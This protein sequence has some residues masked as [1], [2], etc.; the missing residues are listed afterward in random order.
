MRFLWTSAGCYDQIPMNT[1]IHMSQRELNVS[2]IISISEDCQKHW[3]QHT[4]RIKINSNHW[5]KNWGQRGPKHL[6]RTGETN[7]TQRI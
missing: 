6:M 2:N 7:G 1:L 4:F 3:L 5:H